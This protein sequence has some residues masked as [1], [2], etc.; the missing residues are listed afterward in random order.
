MLNLLNRSIFFVVFSVAIVFSMNCKK[1]SRLPPCKGQVIE[2]EGETYYAVEI[3]NQC[4]MDRNLNVGISIDSSQSAENNGTIEKYCY[5]NIDENCEI[6][7]GLYTWWEMMQHTP[8]QR[9]QGICPPGWVVPWED[10]LWQLIDHLG[11][12]VP[13]G[14][15]LKETGFTHWKPPNEGATN[16][17]GFSALPGGR[18]QYYGDGS[19][20]WLGERANIWTSSTPWEPYAWSYNLFYDSDSLGMVYST[21]KYN[22]L[23]VRCIRE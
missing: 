13:A 22:A 11:G 1:D 17:T 5:S 18:L 6:Y 4:W 14:G 3:G 2:Y 12:R 7:G 19:Y 21:H 20:A 8:G 9:G 16:S 10:D 23:S 15:E